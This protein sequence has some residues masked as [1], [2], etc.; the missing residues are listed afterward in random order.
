MKEEIAG[1]VVKVRRKRHRVKAIV[2]TLGRE[3]AEDQT[4]EKVRFYDEMA[5]E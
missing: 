3:V 5:S 2:L 4:Y 1:N